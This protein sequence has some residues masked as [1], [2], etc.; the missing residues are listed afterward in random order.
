[1]CR[2]YR[3]TTGVVSPSFVACNNCL[4]FGTNR[5]RIRDHRTHS[6]SVVCLAG[7]KSAK[8]PIEYIG[9]DGRR[10]STIEEA[11]TPNTSSAVGDPSTQ[12]RPPPW[13][14]GWQTSERSIEWNDDIKLRLLTVLKWVR[15]YG[16][17]SFQALESLM[18]A[19]TVWHVA[20]NS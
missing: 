5:R 9:S 16:M 15:K 6:R 18:Q 12:G 2:A 1:M 14:I 3:H 4:C 10:K 13:S 20:H 19:R 7:E 8:R 11:F 17:Q